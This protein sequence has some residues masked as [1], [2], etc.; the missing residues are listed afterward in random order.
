MIPL[1]VGRGQEVTLALETMPLCLFSIGDTVLSLE[2]GE[3]LER[4]EEAFLG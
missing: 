3:L 1:Q 2:L 4:T